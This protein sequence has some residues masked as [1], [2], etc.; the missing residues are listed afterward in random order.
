MLTT[1]Q[2]LT[3]KNHTKAYLK[4][5]DYRNQYKSFK[6]DNAT[7][8]INQL[9]AVQTCVISNN[10]TMFYIMSPSL[11]KNNQ[12]QLTTFINNIPHSHSTYET[13]DQLVEE[14]NMYFYYN[15]YQISEY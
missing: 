6:Q 9:S 15:Q 2:P 13:I 5:K 14:N 7:K 4:D 12:I 11:Y 8:W 3:G 1:F 10:S